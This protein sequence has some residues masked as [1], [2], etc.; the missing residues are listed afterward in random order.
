M[1]PDDL[2]TLTEAVEYT[3]VSRATMSRWVASGKL[4]AWVSG[5]DARIRLVS[6][7]DLEAV[8]E[9]RPYVPPAAQDDETGKATARDNRAA[10]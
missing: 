7:A 5:R 9:I 10:A 6:R 2:M 8:N 4:R 3:G 1:Q